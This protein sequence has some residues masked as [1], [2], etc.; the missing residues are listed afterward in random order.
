MNLLSCFQ[1][2]M[3]ER[4][5]SRAAERLF[6]TQS[7]V[8]KQLTRLR[9]WF[10]DPLFERSPKGLLPTPKALQIAPQVESILLQVDMLSW[11]EDFDLG[12][13][14]R[15][16][17]F[18]LVETAYSSIY[19]NVVIEALEQ[20]PS[21]QLKTKTWDQQTFERLL[22]RD[23]DFGIGMV[24]YDERASNQVHKLPKDLEC[25]ELV[26]DYSVCLMRPDHPA[27]KID[28]D[29]TAFTQYR[30]I[31]VVTGGVGSWLLMDILNKRDIPLDIALNVPD[32]ES[33]ISVCRHSDLLM[34]YPYSAVKHIVAEGTLVAKPIPIELEPGALFL[35][36]HKFFNTD[37][38]HV[39]MRKLVEM[40]CRNNG[41]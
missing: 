37:P 18:E 29:V 1:V 12:E 8:S 14:E 21:I 5:I 10:D 32:V 30:H 34:C 36:W 3:E 26:R 39:W 40:T 15:L 24:E 25:V 27:L 31:H 19:S 7:A 16:F 22:K 23:A 35:F 13:S 11:Q 17:Q 28:W 33:A 38:S 4:N 41:N 9:G 2:I 20:A 6:L